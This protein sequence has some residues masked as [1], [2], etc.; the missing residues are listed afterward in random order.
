MKYHSDVI[1]VEV[2]CRRW[3]ETTVV[4]ERMAIVVL[5]NDDLQFSVPVGLIAYRLR[6]CH[7]VE[8]IAAQN[9]SIDVIVSIDVLEFVVPVAPI[10]D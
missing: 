6:P 2:K 5:Y 9:P 8:S 7:Y 1:D 3:I 4:C 10:L